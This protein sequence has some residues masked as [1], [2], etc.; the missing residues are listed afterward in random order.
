MSAVPQSPPLIAVVLAGGQS[1]RMGQDKASLRWG[2]QSLWR[3]QAELLRGLGLDVAISVR[4]DQ[5]LP[6]FITGEFLL[7]RDQ[8]ADVGPLS[9]FLSAWR[10]FP[11]HALL[12]VACDL[13]ML[14]VATLQSLLDQRD[15][16]YWATAYTSA[17]DGLPEPLCAIYEPAA[18]KEFE[19]SLAANRRCP[20][21]VL[22]EG[23]D[24]VRL[25]KLLNPIALE[26]ANT[27]EEFERLYALRRAEAQ[28]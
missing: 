16:G 27:P 2:G 17:N 7:I 26:N 12:I 21:K 13:P 11:D 28:A 18:Q 22:I 24:D 23:G 25:L 14:D 4:V 10:Q 6:D 5:K 3:C 19:A 9:G 8:I 1:R 20:R 15:D